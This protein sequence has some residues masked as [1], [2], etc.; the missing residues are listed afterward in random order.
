MV[1]NYIDSNEN[2]VLIDDEYRLLLIKY[3]SSGMFSLTSLICFLF[4]Q[5]I[6]NL[7]A[8]IHFHFYSFYLFILFFSFIFC[9]FIPGMIEC[10]CCQLAL[11][12]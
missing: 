7:L 12:T 10:I 4:I 9:S 6:P 3:S 8:L 5:L 11:S 2:P 1:S